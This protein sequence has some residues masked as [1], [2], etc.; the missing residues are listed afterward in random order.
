MILHWLRLY[1]ERK[2]E[3]AAALRVAA[4]KKLKA[5]KR[6]VEAEAELLLTALEAARQSPDRTTRLF[7]AAT[8]LFVLWEALKADKRWATPRFCRG[9]A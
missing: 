7:L 3:K 4:L 5:E 9:I 1:R 2:R 8:V 6:K